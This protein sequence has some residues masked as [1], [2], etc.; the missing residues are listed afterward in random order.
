MYE[1]NKPFII[2]ALSLLVII[3]SL[4]SFNVFLNNY[5]CKLTAQGLGLK[6]QFSLIA[7]CRVVV[8]ERLVPIRFIRIVDNE[9]VIQGD[10][11]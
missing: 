6:H 4:I 1:D 5:E 2:A 3:V 10:S 8:G 11:E 7:G 9:I